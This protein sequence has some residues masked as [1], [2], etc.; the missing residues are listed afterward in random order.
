MPSA[1]GFSFM[2]KTLFFQSKPWFFHPPTNQQ[3]CWRCNPWSCYSAF[4]TTK[5]TRDS[6][7]FRNCFRKNSSSRHDDSAL[8][9][10]WPIASMY[11]IFAYIYHKNQ[12]NVG[13]YTIHGSYGWGKAFLLLAM[14][15]L[16]RV[17]AALNGFMPFTCWKTFVTI[18]CR[19]RFFKHDGNGPCH[20]LWP[21]LAFVFFK[22]DYTAWLYGDY[23][24]HE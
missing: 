20:C 16:G 10:C 18:A 14:R 8:P 9:G 6:R 4:Q 17:V 23:N 1:F 13:K 11:S 2:A 5:T 12:P 24:K 3:K 21:G 22:E 7:H 15:C 19:S